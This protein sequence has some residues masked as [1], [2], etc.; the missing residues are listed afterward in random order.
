MSICTFL[1]FYASKFCFVLSVVWMSQM[2]II[3]RLS[4]V[5]SF[6]N[7]SLTQCHVACFIN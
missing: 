5:R 3:C 4:S 6:A 7:R 1:L 2:E